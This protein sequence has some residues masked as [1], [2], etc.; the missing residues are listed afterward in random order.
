[1]R[2]RSRTRREPAKTRRRKAVTLKRRNAPKAVR[3]RSSSDADLSEQIAL[4][5]R[6]RDEALARENA[7]GE[8]LSS[9][10]GSM[11][12]AK[13]VFDAIVR[14]LLRL[15][16]NPDNTWKKVETTEAAK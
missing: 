8:I 14:N 3:R 5:K 7:I 2:Q 9:I 12:D 6:E 1:M 16:F 10:S 13:P 11:T 4:F 15:S